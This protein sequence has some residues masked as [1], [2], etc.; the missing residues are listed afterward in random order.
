LRILSNRLKNKINIK[1]VIVGL[2][3]DKGTVD[4]L[5]KLIEGSN[6]LHYISID[7]IWLL[8]R[9]IMS[10]GKLN[11]DINFVREKHEVARNKKKN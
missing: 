4:K 9:I 5:K 6:S 2:N 10:T 3:P 1:I 8:R 7:N 11:E